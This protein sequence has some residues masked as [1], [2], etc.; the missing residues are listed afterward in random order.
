MEMQMATEKSDDK[1][2]AADAALLKARALSALLD[3]ELDEASV[4]AACADWREREDARASWH[5]YHLI[6]DVMRSDDL[7]TPV[8]RDLDFMAGLRAR[9]AQEPVVLAPE[10]LATPAAVAPPVKVS[11]PWRNAMAV[12]AGFAAVGV[13]LVV[14]QMT[15]GTPTASDST[16]A[17]GPSPL[18][19]TVS[20]ASAPQLERAADRVV[21]PAD[22]VLNG[23]LVRDARLD[24]YL[25]AHKKFG[26]S[27]AP[28]GPSGFLRNAAAD[29]R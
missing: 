21:E 17:Q 24:D 14:T 5:A 13:V 22:D 7:A 27:S 16:L 26:G 4:G 19:T 11:R 29:G 18:V 20:V 1:S 8:S 12:A 28:G 6:G 3:G 15:G 9:L 2:R 25:A 10:P 23:K